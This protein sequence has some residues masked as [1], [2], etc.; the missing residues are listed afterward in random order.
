MSAATLKATKKQSIVRMPGDDTEEVETIHVGVGRAKK[1]GPT[2]DD[3]PIEQKAD[4]EFPLN[5]AFERPGAEIL[6][7]PEQ[8][9][10]EYADALAFG[11]DPIKVFILPSQHE[12]GSPYAE[13]WV[14][15]EG[16]ELWD[17]QVKRWYKVGVVPR[18]QEIITKRKYVEVLLRS[19]T[20]AKQTVIENR[21]TDPENF[22]KT[23]TVPSYP[24]Q[25]THDPSPKGRE[26]LARMTGL[27][28]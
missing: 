3:Y 26:W 5:E 23:I 24:L 25:V 8:L 14:N 6:K 19:K 12:F 7:S 9:E 13:C 16:M 11:N 18:G 17:T 2:T 20:D 4:F 1:E 10:K 21:H 27:R 28:M 15:G 22:L